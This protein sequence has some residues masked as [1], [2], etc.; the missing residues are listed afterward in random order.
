MK[1]TNVAMKSLIIFLLSFFAGLSVFA[2]DNGKTI[3]QDR[4]VPEF[5]SIEISQPVMVYLSQGET[6]GVKVEAPEN[7]QDKIKIDVSN[8][9]LTVNVNGNN[10]NDLKIYITVKELKKIETSGAAM[11]QGQTVIKS[12]KLEIEAE[13]ASEVTLD[14]DVN[15]LVSS[16]SGASEIKLTGKA[17]THNADVSGAASLKAEDMKTQKTKI[18]VSGAAYAKVDAT[19]EL[20]GEVSGAANLNYKNKP[21]IYDVQESG[22]ASS[23]ISDSASGD[24]SDTTKFKFGDKHFMFFNDKFPHHGGFGQHDC[25]KKDKVKPQ[26]AGLELGINGYMDKDF[27]FDQPAGY[28][29]L[30]PYYGRSFSVGL[31]VFEIG[32]PLVRKHMTLVTGAGFEFNNYFY[33][34]NYTLLSDTSLVTAIQNPASDFEK[35]K[36]TISWFRVP[37]LLQFDSKKFHHGGTFHFSMGVIGAIKIGSYT[38]QTW[39]D[40]DAVYKTK[41]RDDFNLSP[42][43]A[44][45]TLRI[46]V[47]YLNLFVNYSLNSMFRNNHGPDLFPVSAGITLVNI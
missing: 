28:G 1:T 12:D 46:G 30:E 35:N 40:G 47:G 23:D 42:F 8:N 20:K 27:K 14:L 31:N 7:I 22:A 15:D 5:N 32:V 25:K 37:L 21:P 41:T 26:W 34:N 29:Y 11:I 19:D 6:A 43:K 10:T 18:E 16:A 17:S 13:G 3:T 4:T 45:A 2:Q 38:K 24:A 44:D 9:T 33:K 39:K 36:L